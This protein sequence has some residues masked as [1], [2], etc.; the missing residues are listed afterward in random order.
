MSDR[1]IRSVLCDSLSLS[2]HPIYMGFVLPRYPVFKVRA[3]R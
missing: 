3:A 1:T 2:W